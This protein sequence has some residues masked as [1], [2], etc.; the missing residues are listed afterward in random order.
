MSDAALDRPVRVA[1]PADVRLLRLGL[2]LAAAV[3]AV[4]LVLP[5]GTLLLRAFEDTDGRFVGLANFIAYVTT[6]ALLVRSDVSLAPQAYLQASVVGA[7]VS[8]AAL[9]LQLVSTGA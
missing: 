4:G 7:A 9:I 6:P 8:E 1:L 3:L 2:W 5:L